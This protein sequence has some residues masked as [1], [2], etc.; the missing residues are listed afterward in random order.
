M[1][2]GRIAHLI[3]SLSISERV[4]RENIEISSLIIC[5]DKKR[6]WHLEKT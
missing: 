1:N 3:W 4:I 6:A 2:V 5:T